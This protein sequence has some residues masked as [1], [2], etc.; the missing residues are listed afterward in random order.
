M[1]PDA[2]ASETADTTSPAAASLEDAATTKEARTAVRVDTPFLT[3]AD[4]TELERRATEARHEL[5]SVSGTRRK[6][7]LLRATINDSLVSGTPFTVLALTSVNELLECVK[8]KVC[9]GSVNI[10]KGELEFGIA[11]KLPLN[12]EV[13]GQVKTTWSSPRVGTNTTCNPFEVNVLAAR[14]AASTGNGQTAL[15]DIFAAL[16]ISRR[17]T[18]Y[19]TCQGYLKDKLNPSTALNAAAQV[20]RDCAGAVKLAYQN[21]N[22][23]HPANIAVSFD[24]TWLTRG[25]SSHV[26][27]GTVIELFTGYV[28]D[29]VV[30]SN[31]C[32][33]CHCGL[34]EDDPEFEAWQAEHKFQKNTSSKP[35]EMEVEAAR[36]LFSRSLEKYGLRYV[37]MLCDGDSHAFNNL[38]EAKAYGYVQIQKE[39][40]TNHVSKRMGTAL[41]N[42]VHKKKENRPSLS[43][44]GKLTGELITKLTMYYGWALKTHQGDIEKMHNAV[45]ATYHHVTST[46]AETNHGLCPQGQESW[47]KY[48]QALA[49]NEP[50]PKHRY[51]LPKYVADAL[52]PVFVRLSDRK[53]LERCQRGKMQNSNESLHSVIWSLVPKTKQASLFAVQSA[54]AEPVTRVNAGKEYAT[55]AILQQLSVN[56]GTAA[57][58]RSAEK[59]R[60]W[61]ATS[62]AKHLQAE[63]FRSAMKKRTTERDSDYMPGAF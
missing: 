23:D 36:I 27:V 17:G 7:S 43:G 8:C 46:D 15:N 34:K 21:L 40:C 58:E 56:H 47:C 14:A 28:L 19:K 13:C 30:L 50:P 52:Q 53:L 20:M 41:R 60:R 48:N 59:D 61:L 54:V 25:H 62:D 32:L 49:K 16:N 10:S 2:P 63:R 39:D 22:F 38:Q 33:G 57:I 55:K 3:D 4:K 6:R 1:S 5:S 29:F 11:V 45:L 24:G 37:T 9:G 12:C 35:G 44:K 26:C 18:H 42:L 51:N 31:F